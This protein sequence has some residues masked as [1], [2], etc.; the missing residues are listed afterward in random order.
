M[1]FDIGLIDN[2]CCEIKDH[3]FEYLNIN[4]LKATNSYL[5]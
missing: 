5:F 3:I 1:T 2:L 4:V